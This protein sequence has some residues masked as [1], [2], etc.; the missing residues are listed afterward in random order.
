VLNIGVSNFSREVLE[1]LLAKLDKSEYPA[2]NQ[3]EAHPY[4]PQ[5]ELLQYCTSNGIHVTAYSPLGNNRK[6]WVK[7]TYD[8]G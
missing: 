3:I 2:V 4:L 1:Q 8:I 7:P 5:D 6:P